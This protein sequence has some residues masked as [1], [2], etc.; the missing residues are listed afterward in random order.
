MPT[1]GRIGSVIRVPLERIA[2]TLKACCPV[3]G[4]FC[5]QRYAFPPKAARWSPSIAWT[6]TRDTPSAAIPYETAALGWLYL[7]EK[8][9][10]PTIGRIGAVASRSR[11][12]GA[13]VG[14]RL[15]P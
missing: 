15:W 1:D 12:A 6:T 13:Q 14:P 2:V 3:F 10:T 8:P 11:D 5:T 4:S 9:E 7:S